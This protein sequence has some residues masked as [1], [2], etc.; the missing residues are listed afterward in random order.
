MTIIRHRKDVPTAS[1]AD[2]LES[3][4][5]Y[6]GKSIKKFSSREAAETQTSNA[7]MAAEDA[8]GKLGVKKGAK[9]VAMTAAELDAARAAK[10]MGAEVLSKPTGSAQAATKPEPKGKSLR[11]KLSAKAVGEPNKG[12]AKPQK[13]EPG[14]GRAP[15]VTHV[16]LLPDGRSKMQAGS[17]RRGVYDAIV[18]AAAKSKI[19]AADG[20]TPLV[21]VD[22]LQDDFH[23]P[24]RGH[25]LKLIF[26]GRIAA[27]E[28]AQA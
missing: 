15:K 19:R 9:P 23:S 14:A 10:A 3:Y 1:T 21:N 18:G 12:K 7:I 22:A 26:E 8:A 16:K 6:T 2:L 4:N 11:E 17:Q 13:K 28:P 25:I 5:A 20:V 27:E 24:I